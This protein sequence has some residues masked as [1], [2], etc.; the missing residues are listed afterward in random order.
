MIT[1]QNTAWQ[2]AL[3]HAASVDLAICDPIYADPDLSYIR[4]VA[5]TLKPGGSVYVFA[6]SSGVAQTKLELDNQPNLHFQN[7]LIWGPND[8]GGRSKTRWGQKHDDILFYTR[9]GAPHCFNG[10]AVAVPKMMT[11]AVFNPSGRS[12]KIPHSVWSDLAGFATT[13][14]ERVRINGVSIRWQKPEKVIER[15]VLASSQ[16]GDLVWV[17]F[18]GVATVPVVCR[19]LQR[20]C[21]ATELD[22]VVWAAGFERMKQQ[23]LIH[24]GEASTTQ[25]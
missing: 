4:C 17:P 22:S 21:W 2:E 13:S 25:T 16:P 7:W 12:T 5:E 6:D 9:V 3:P 24:N 19:R 20:E 8:W 1:Y 23:E 11:Q 10:D 14:S 18:A 15:I